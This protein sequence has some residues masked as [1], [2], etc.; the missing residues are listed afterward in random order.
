MSISIRFLFIGAVVIGGCTLN[1]T[2][3]NRVNSDSIDLTELNNKQL[4]S[5][6]KIF[7]AL[8]SPTESAHLLKKS[9]AIYDE[10]LLHSL[11]AASGYTTNQSMALNLGVYISDLSYASLFDQTQT[12]LNYMSI[13]KK[14]ADRL[15]ILDAIDQSTLNSIEEN[16]GNKDEIISIISESFMS[17]TAYLE[18]SGRNETAVMV[19]IGS[20]IEGIYV[21]SKVVNEHK[22]PDSR[23]K[24]Q[25]IDQKLNFELLGGMLEQYSQSADIASLIKLLEPLKKQFDKVDVQS[26]ETVT[27]FDERSGTTVIDSDTRCQMSPSDFAGLTKEIILLRTAIVKL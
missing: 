5:A 25:L 6:K 8:P 22:Q 11:S 15:H 27:K 9:G 1:P 19:L 10:S 12:A 4:Q 20:W 24:Q 26:S 23:L 17:S 16:L 18:E 2:P 3:P 14:L 7:Y 21:A 13:A